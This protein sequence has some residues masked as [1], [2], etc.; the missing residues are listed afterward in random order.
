M[1]VSRPSASSPLFFCL[2]AF[3]SLPAPPDSLP[4]SSPPPSAMHTPTPTPTLPS[5][6]PASASTTVER[7]CGR[8][9]EVTR[10]GSV[11]GAPTHIIFVPG[12]PGIPAYYGSTV[13]MLAEQLGATAAVVGFLGH[14]ATPTSSPVTQTFG[15][16][17]L[18]A[19]CASVA[20][21]LSL[22]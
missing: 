14:S 18:A 22:L 7:S 5:A 4:L 15:A 12:N 19:P 17:Y 21:A 3:S 13:E 10:V 1:C 6:I 8:A 20:R 2:L 16:L 11:G 9:V